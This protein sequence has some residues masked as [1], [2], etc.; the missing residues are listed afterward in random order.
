MAEP[1]Q[2]AA[3]NATQENEQS[4]KVESPPSESITQKILNSAQGVFER[5]GVVFKRGRGRPRADGMPAKGDVPINAPLKALPACAAP[6]TPLP[7]QAGLDPALVR[8]CCSAVLKGVSGV[9]DKILFRKAKLATNDHQWAQQ[10]VADTAITK[11]EMDSFS[12]LAEVCLRKYGVGTEYAPE[13]G[14]GCIVL[15]VGIRYGAALKSLDSEIRK[16]A[17]ASNPSPANVTPL[18]K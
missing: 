14:L 2:S 13:I 9:L 18:N 5:H 8:R 10:L 15:G 3:A 7:D 12:E 4:A 11:E 17:Q 6:P 16:Q 1:A